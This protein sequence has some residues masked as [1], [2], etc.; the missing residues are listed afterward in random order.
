MRAR[1]SI[2]VRPMSTHFGPSSNSAFTPVQSYFGQ[3]SLLL[4][5]FFT[6][7]QNK[8]KMLGN[9]HKDLRIGKFL[10][11]LGQESVGKFTESRGAVHAFGENGP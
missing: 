10:E 6:F 7:L 4:H 2:P 1:P 5:V 3:L 8:L 11:S 9:W